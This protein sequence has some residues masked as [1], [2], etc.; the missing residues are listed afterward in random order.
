MLTEHRKLRTG[1]SVWLEQPLP[2]IPVAPLTHDVRADVLVV[3]AGVTGALVAEMLSLDRNVVVIDR[4]GPAEGSTAASTALVSYEIDVPL[5]EL[6]KGIG[7]PDAERAWRRAYQAV[8]ALAE[9]TETLRIDC[10]FDRRPSLY[11]AGPKLAG[12]ALAGEA[13]ARREAGLAVTYLPRAALAERYRIDRDGAILAA[14]EFQADPRRFAAGYLRAAIARGAR[15]YAPVEA[16]AI[17]E[18]SDGAVVATNA[19]PS[20]RARHVVY[21]TG[22]ELPAVLEGRGHRRVSTY[23]IATVPQALRHPALACVIAE[24]ADPYLYLREGPDGRIVCGG[25]DEPFADA[26]A[27]DALIP[28]KVEAICAK[29]A[30]L[31]PGVDTTPAFARLGG[32]VWRKRDGPAVDWLDSRLAHD[33]GGAGF[34]R[35][36]HGLRAHRR[37]DH[38][39]R[40]NG[41]D[42]PRRRSLRDAVEGTS[43]QE[44]RFSR[45]ESAHVAVAGVVEVAA[46]QAAAIGLVYVQDFTTGITR[47][48]T[49]TGFTYLDPSGKAI[50]DADKLHRIGRIG[51]PPAWEDV[52][53]APNANGHIQAI[54]WDARGRKQYRYH[55]DFRS[56]RDSTKFGHVITFARALPRLRRQV[57]RDMRLPGLPRDKVL[58][59]LV[60]L[61]DL[62]LLRIG[63]EDYARQNHSF[64]LTT[65][66]DRHARVKG[67]TLHLE[68]KGKSGQH[69][70]L[71]VRDRR[72]ARI[73]K[74]CQDL[75]GQHLFQYRDGEGEHQA[76]GSADVNRYLRTVTGAEITAKDF[77]TWGATVLAAAALTRYPPYDTQ[78]LAKA[79]LK[80]AIDCVSGELGNTPAVC[81]NSYI[82][83]GVMEGYLAGDLAAAIGPGRRGNRYFTATE[84]AVMAYVERIGRAVRRSTKKP[85]RN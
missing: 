55:V 13:A 70:R 6:A 20:I 84:A 37:R 31:L 75:P 35:Q 27:R 24:A 63:N 66:L 30:A 76:V 43:R 22:Y 18:T 44:M 14:G 21:C 34:R 67:D 58:A 39:C 77:R 9:R 10:G 82:H 3:G 80:A 23:A 19:G 65:L 85:A 72:V 5:L 69:W 1:A 15:L 8:A 40:T 36:R 83:P 42:R 52:W 11:L 51:I 48:R 12:A 33:A 64:G 56:H 46:K 81:R 17:E 78:T 74:A 53:I 54:G 41:T 38:P 57:D 59:T 50:R 2:L 47:R 60:D 26:A 79:N 28:Q 25:E 45:M 29:L 16:I 71:D 7:R 62:T 73:V 68:F 49:A 32:N 61:L 4:R